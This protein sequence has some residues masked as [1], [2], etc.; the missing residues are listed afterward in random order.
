MFAISITLWEVIKSFGSTSVF[1]SIDESK[2]LIIEIANKF[3]GENRESY[4]LTLMHTKQW[5]PT[6]DNAPSNIFRFIIESIPY[7]IFS[8]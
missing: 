6:S 8:E 4:N 5:G 2:R 1:E 3:F 7:F